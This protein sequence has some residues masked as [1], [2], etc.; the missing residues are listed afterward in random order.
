MMVIVNLQS[1]VF[2]LN[3]SATVCTTL[4]VKPLLNANISRRFSNYAIITN[5]LCMYVRYT[6]ESD[7]HS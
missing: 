2:F 7:A 1:L 5:L 4:R 3:K 6:N